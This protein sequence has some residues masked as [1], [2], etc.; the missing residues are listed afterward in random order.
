MK[1]GSC[2]PP[3]PHTR[4]DILISEGMSLKSSYVWINLFACE[5]FR[6]AYSPWSTTVGRSLCAPNKFL[7]TSSAPGRAIFLLAV[8]NVEN[9]L[10]SVNSEPALG[11]SSE[12]IWAIQ[13]IERTYLMYRRAALEQGFAAIPFTQGRCLV[14]T[15]LAA[16]A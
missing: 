3:T 8:L 7:N 1:A 11:S 6:S 10:S 15:T 14:V 9:I 5:L 16:I 2:W 12:M 13:E 4:S